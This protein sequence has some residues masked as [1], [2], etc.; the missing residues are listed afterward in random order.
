M[1]TGLVGTLAKGTAMPPPRVLVVDDESSVRLMLTRLLQLA[2]YDAVSAMDGAAGYAMLESDPTIQFVVL[3][4][5]MPRM[6]GWKFRQLQ[7]QDARLTAVPTVILTG[8]P[9]PR[10]VDADLRAVDY[11]LKPVSLER[12]LSVVRQYCGPVSDEADLMTVAS[13]PGD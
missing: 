13:L 3:D 9:L 5:M 8:A 10:I 12:L 11:L 6:D 4:L 1:S 7:Q 2:G